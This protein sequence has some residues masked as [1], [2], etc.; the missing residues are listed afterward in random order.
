M[1][2]HCRFFST[3]VLSSVISILCSGSWS[4]STEIKEVND[5]DDIPFLD[6]EKEQELDEFHDNFGSWLEEKAVWFDSFFDEDNYIEETNETNAKASL[7]VGYSRKDDIEFS[8]RFRLRLRLPH[9][10]N[11]ARLIISASDD[12]GLSDDSTSLIGGVRDNNDRDD[13]TAGIQYFLRQSVNDHLSLS[14]GASFDYLYAGV[15]ARYSLDYGEWR[16]RFT[17]NLRYYTDDGWENKASIEMD[18]P[19]TEKLMF[20]GILRADWYED[21][22]GLDHSIHSRVYQFLDVHHSLRYDVGFYF[23]T[24]SNYYME[25]ARFQVTHRQRFGRDWLALEISPFL[26]FPAEN[27]REVNP[28]LFFKFE[29]EFGYSPEGRGFNLNLINR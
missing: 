8:P 3:F 7:S 5:P 27:D 25:D 26:T 20:R 11:K 14:G 4:Y 16:N 19:L 15:R 12:N 22:N 18:H 1:T 17:N 24:R 6:D 23:K 13:L 2:I 10:E 28:G 9:L 21:Q 29:A